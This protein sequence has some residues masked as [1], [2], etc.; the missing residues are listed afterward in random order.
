MESGWKRGRD[1]ERENIDRVKDRQS[2]RKIE[3]ER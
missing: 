2:E 1:R 3:G